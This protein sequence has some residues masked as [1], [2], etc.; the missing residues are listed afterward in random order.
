MGTPEFSAILEQQIRSARELDCKGDAAKAES[1]WDAVVRISPAHAEARSRLARFAMDRGDPQRAVQL[2]QPAARA[3]PEDAT[4][5]IDLALALISTQQPRSAMAALETAVSHQPGSINAWLLLGEIRE[6][7]GDATGALKAWYQAVTR[8]QRAGLWRG[9]SSTPKH[10][11]Q[12]VMHAIEIVRAGRRELLITSYDIVRE[13]FG[14]SELQ[15]VDRALAGYLGDWDATP[16][17][18]R[19]R[20]KF[21]YFPDLPSTPFLD[22]DLQPWV[23]RLRDAFPVIRDEALRVMVEDEVFEHFVQLKGQARMSDFVGG[24]G[25]KPSWEAFFFYRR[26]MRFD[27]NHRRCPRTSELLESIELCRIADQ[28][29]EI[30][31]SL[32]K[33]GSHIL[34]HFG[35]SNTRAVMHLP[36]VVPPDCALHLIGVGEHHW[37]EGEA[38]LFDD[39]FEHEAWNRS[40]ENRLI[41]LMDCWNPHLTA[42]ERLALTELVQTISGLSAADDARP[43]AAP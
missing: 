13:R 9:I 34:P 30:C 16:P 26:G 40:D 22:P 35:V 23:G 14:W 27:E 8:A 17:D 18:T 37:Q 6:V 31:F 41:L 5:A 12:A 15:R 20:P 38:M 11:L 21:L 25:S 36:L 1:A 39:T 43:L 29:P 7:G 10:L 4:L 32:L 3:H 24:I 42:A 28:T 19:Q 2:L 33:A